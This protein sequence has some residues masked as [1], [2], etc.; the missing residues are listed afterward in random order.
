MVSRIKAITSGLD[1]GVE[2]GVGAYL[3]GGLFLVLFVF[4]QPV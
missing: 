4:T 2:L 1:L 3:Y